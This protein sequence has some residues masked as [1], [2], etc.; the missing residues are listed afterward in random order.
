M[1]ELA[2]QQAGYLGIESVRRADGFGITVS[3]WSSLDAVARWKQQVEHL[4]AQALGKA[5]W[6]V[7]YAVRVARVERS[8][9]KAKADRAVV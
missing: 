4:G 7:D 2:P 3:Y 5:K 9:G 6:Y 1:A 8:Y